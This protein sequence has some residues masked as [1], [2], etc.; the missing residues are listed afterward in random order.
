MVSRVYFH[1]RKARVGVLLNGTIGWIYYGSMEESSVS[2]VYTCSGRELQLREP[3]VLDEDNY[4]NGYYGFEE[5]TSLE[6][7][8]LIGISEDRVRRDLNEKD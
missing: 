1:R 3:S 7:L 8:M 5:M 4:N 6:V 2:V